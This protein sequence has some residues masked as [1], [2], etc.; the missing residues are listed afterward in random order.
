V[1]YIIVSSRERPGREDLVALP[2]PSAGG[3]HPGRDK[4][5]SPAEE[6]GS[7]RPRADRSS[8]AKTEVPV[9]SRGEPDKSPGNPDDPG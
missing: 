3:P 6:S 2:Q 7:D 1:T 5:P 8:D 4:E 9:S